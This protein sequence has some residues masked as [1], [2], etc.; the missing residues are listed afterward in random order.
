VS[1]RP[2]EGVKVVEVAQFTYVPS[3]GATLADWGATVYKIE[4]AFTGDAQRGMLGYGPA[5]VV[6]GTYSPIMEHPNRGKRSIGLDVGHPEGLRV[7]HRMVEECDVFLT[8]FLPEARARLH[9]DVE[10]IR[11][12]N[13][14]VIYARGSAL[15]HRGPESLKGG[16]DSASYWARGGG[17]MG[18]TPPDLSAKPLNM[19]APAHGDTLGGLTIAG[20]VAA[21]LF[22]RAT[23]GEPSVVDVSLLSVG[24]YAC[25]LSVDISLLTGDPWVWPPNELPGAPVNPVVGYFETADAKWIYLAMLQPGRYWADF[26]RHIEREDL[27]DDPRFDTD[28]KLIANAQEAAFIV[29]AELLTRPLDEWIECFHDLEGQWS[30]VQDSVQVGHDEQLRA[31]GYF[32]PVIDADGKPRELITNPIQFDERPTVTT[33]APQFS[34][35]T[36]EVLAEFGYTEE[37]ILQLKIDGAAT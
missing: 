4:H 30:V 26:C 2:M 5:A 14:Q 9:I 24:A 1:S 32:A 34:E 21:A 12:V 29:Q 15:G 31:M 19:P 36:D 33:R 35:H 16:F 7:L 25:A 8:N 28:E 22:K 6:E 23:T 11:A 3:A 20:G 18:V 13:P 17:S 10:D 37:Q 27:V